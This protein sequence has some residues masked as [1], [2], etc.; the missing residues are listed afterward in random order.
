MKRKIL[1]VIESL[2]ILVTMLTPLHACNEA[3]QQIGMAV[4][5][6]ISGTISNSC[7]QIPVLIL[8]PHNPVLQ[9]K[10]QTDATSSF[11]ISKIIINL[12]GTTDLN[13]I[14]TI[15]LIYLG[16]T[17]ISGENLQIGQISSPTETV[18]F[19][20]K[21]SISGQ[22]AFFSVLILLKKNAEL[23]HKVKASCESI[24]TNSG[25]IKA[26]EKAP[27]NGFRIGTALRQHGDEGI[28]T[29]RIPGLTTSRN[30]TLLAIY[31][32]RRE[33]SRDLQ[34]NMDIGVSRS[35]D[36]G[37]SWE[38]MKIALD[39]GDWGKLPQKFNGI[40]DACI[41]VNEQNNDI[42]IAG[43]WMY[44]VLDKN[45]K[46]IER[47]NESSTDWQHQWSGKGS[48]PG[49]GE[50]QTCQFLITKST[51]DGQTWSEPTNLTQM[52]K[53]EDWWLFAPAPGHGITLEDGTLVFPTQ[54]RDASGN[55]FSNITWSKDG[56][57]TWHTSNPASGG[58]TENMVAQLSDGSIML[59]ARDGKNKGNT[60]STNG[61]VISTSNDLG[62]SWIIHSSS[63]GALMEPGCMAGLHKH[64]YSENGQKKSIL[65]FSNPSSKTDRVN[66]TIKVSFD[67]GKT[68]PEKYWLLLDEKKGRGYSCLTSIDEQTIGILYESSQADMVFQKISLKEIIGL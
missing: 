29:Y 45:G 22:S 15:K 4:D 51:D 24:E 55:S 8:K 56:G 30:G 54:G 7:E 38:P 58:T 6:K 62:K 60:S 43:L 1:T 35:I 39:R 23:F 16:P 3:G 27:G 63:R 65:L 47:L 28:D 32:V 46:W 2:I 61:R 41:L 21:L 10:L 49:F 57:T 12:E 20:D 48:Q 19:N 13:D 67:D 66:M 34:G 26:S 53:K 50:K 25:I 40:S 33:S 64:V 37:D 14:E 18:I 42:F 36:G 44:G 5:A 11:T 52:C 9:I 68:W 17:S 59:N 31:D